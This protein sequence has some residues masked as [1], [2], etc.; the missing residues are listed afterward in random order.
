MTIKRFVAFILGMGIAICLFSGCKSPGQ[1]SA[2]AA[3]NTD[4]TSSDQP[5]Q[6]PINEHLTSGLYVLSEDLD[7]A[8]F[9]DVSRSGRLLLSHN[10]NDDYVS[11]IG[12]KGACTASTRVLHSDDIRITC[13]DESNTRT[14]LAG[15]TQ[16]HSAVWM[17]NSD[18][19]LEPVCAYETEQIPLDL[20]VGSAGDYYMIQGTV[21]EIPVLDTISYENT[22]L[23]HFDSQGTLIQEIA[24]D[25]T[26]RMTGLFS[27]SGDHPYLITN[28]SAEDG[29]VTVIYSIQE[30][31][32]SEYDVLPFGSACL[33]RN[34][35]NESL[36]L[37][38]EGNL[39]QYE[40]TG[41]TLEEQLKWVNSNVNGNAVLGGA[42]ISTDVIILWS[43]HQAWILQPRDESAEI[44]TIRVAVVE[45]N[46]LPVQVLLDFQSNYPNITVEAAAFPDQTAL[47]L[48]L[49]AGEPLDLLQIDGM[50]STRY[51]RAG[52]LQNLKDR[53]DQ[54][55]HLNI[56][57]F[58]AK[59]WDI[60]YG[61]QTLPTVITNF[62]VQG[63]Y[64]PAEN[65]QEGPYLDW[66]TFDQ[67]TENTR[68]Y[69][70][71]VQENALIWLCSVSALGEANDAI[72]LDLDELARELSAAKLFQKDFESVDYNIGGTELS[73]Q[74]L[75]GASFPAVSRIEENGRRL[76]GTDDLS[77]W[78]YPSSKKQGLSFSC[79]RSY[80][81]LSSS[82]YPD[83]AWMLLRYILLSGND[84]VGIP[85]LRQKDQ[86]MLDELISLVD[87]EAYG[88]SSP[89]IEI[90]LDEAG[91]YFNGDRDLEDVVDLI[92]NR[93][94]I[95]LSE[96]S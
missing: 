51:V 10:D 25:I 36:Y 35:I 50:D 21:V 65:G 68:F 42:M 91:A 57:D 54:D 31:S 5:V 32:L 61:D 43:D 83:E 37:S 13:V 60:H 48:A 71:T 95:Y 40:L 93:V 84:D 47:N 12:E 30:E 2:Q 82:E 64:G 9:L 16:G 23:L 59:I 19:E 41:Q 70:T 34:G 80:G 67:L 55:D 94:S 58:Y 87:N 24:L 15:T 72:S 6:T 49:T 45:P 44:I 7:S 56:Q 29:P 85:I 18:G 53:F 52:Y 78:G 28:R 14:Y 73:L 86:P 79:T 88:S 17:L 11:Q 62:N 22:V 69:E 27:D 90:I 1:T 4:T 63:L 39:Y 66:D 76:W 81:M 77:F 89:V 92:D 38:A 74:W 75:N 26:E 20:L 96:Q 46:T 8:S 3:D 33:L